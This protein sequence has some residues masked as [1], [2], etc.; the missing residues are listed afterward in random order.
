MQLELSVIIPVYNGE[1]YIN[2]CIESIFLQENISLE[3]I[4]IDDK[5][6]DKTKD[7]CQNFV[8]DDR[9]KY[10][11]LPENKGQ[12]YCR[13]YGLSIATGAYILFIDA[14]DYLS[15]E[16]NVLFKC[17]EEVTI[18][19]L[20]ILDCP[21][22]LIDKNVEV[23]NRLT[24]DGVLK[25]K[26]YLNQIEVLS[27]VVWNKIFRKDFLIAKNLKFKDRKYEDVT[28]NVECFL[29]AQRVSASNTIFYNYLIH[30][31]S[32]MT[33]KPQ[34]KNV[35]DVIDLVVDLEQLYNQDGTIYQV[36][37]TFFYSFIGAARIISNYKG[38]LNEI[39]GY[40]DTYNTLYKKYRIKM[41]KSKTLN[42]VLR[43]SLL[44]S[45]FLANRILTALKK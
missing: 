2:R 27:V 14:D 19:T 31:N 18:K 36:E 34:A 6:T 15:V 33:S 45:P 29:K 5:S 12:G 38:D 16:S 24:V 10:L 41:S 37:K 23:K 17:I 7:I 28:F 1:Q 39:S 13:N 44:L 35:I 9:F 8:G 42:I 20:D 30:E 43:F 21:Y 22:L 26:E 4:V 32:T 11:M 25:G 3:V 40:L